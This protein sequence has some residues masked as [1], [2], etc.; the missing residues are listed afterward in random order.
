MDILR[1]A[2]VK[3]GAAHVWFEGADGLTGG[4]YC[5]SLPL[6]L[7][8]DPAGDVLVAYEM[9]RA[10][11]HPDHGFPCRLVAP[12]TVGG[13]NVKWLAKI[14]LADH[15]AGELRGARAAARAPE[16]RLDSVGCHLSS[17]RSRRRL[18]HYASSP[19]SAPRA[20]RAAG[21]GTTTACSR[22][23]SCATACPWRR[24]TSTAPSGR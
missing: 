18:I 15:E 13:R 4:P 14:T 5:T 2:R 3:P 19:T 23:P 1:E 11:L 21:T 10:R 16:R 17:R 24:A 9:N 22:P 7:A 8:L 20:Q 6:G 12:G